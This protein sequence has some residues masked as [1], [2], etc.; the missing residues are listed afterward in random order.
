MNKVLL[1][2]PVVTVLAA[3][4]GEPKQIATQA[5]Y[6]ASQNGAKAICQANADDYV[7]A[8]GEKASTYVMDTDSSITREYLAGDGWCSGFKYKKGKVQRE[9]LYCRS[10][11]I[12]GGCK[13]V[14]PKDD[15]RVN[16]NLDH[17]KPVG[18]S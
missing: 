15:G 12:G 4:G 10:S 5:D 17:S 18:K 9:K 14:K 8:T 7:L 6:I 2:L 13:P 1:I 16:P 3:C 11:H